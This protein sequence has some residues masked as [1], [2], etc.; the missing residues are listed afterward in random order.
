MSKEIVLSD[1]DVYLHIHIHRYMFSS[2][3]KIVFRTKNILPFTIMQKKVEG[4]VLNK[5]S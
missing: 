5:I 4:I 3:E 2:Q 1:I